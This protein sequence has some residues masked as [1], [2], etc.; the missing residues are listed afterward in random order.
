MRDATLSFFARLLGLQPAA[1]DIEL[2]MERR[3]DPRIDAAN[4]DWAAIGRSM[5]GGVQTLRDKKILK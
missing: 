4:P 2:P 3:R 5:K 1:Q